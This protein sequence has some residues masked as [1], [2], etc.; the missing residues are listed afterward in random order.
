[1]ECQP[2]TAGNYCPYDDENENAC[3]AGTWS[4]NAVEFCHVCPPGYEC[5]DTHLPA[6]NY[7]LTGTW[8]EGKLA[9]CTV[10]DEGYECVGTQKIAC[11]GTKWSSR[12]DGVCK[13]FEGGQSGYASGGNW[14]GSGIAQ[15]EPC[16]DGQFSLFGTVTCT[17]C[18]VGHYCETSR[19]SFMPKNCV[20]GEY[21]PSTK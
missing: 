15:F 10:C 7:C 5:P 20:P 1:M 12:G 18:P 21:Q 11:S 16:D 9:A 14:D 6:M 4:L 13:F 3:D 8:S 17:D 19:M 2:C